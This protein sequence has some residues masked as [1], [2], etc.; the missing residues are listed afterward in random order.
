MSNHELVSLVTVENV[1]F[2]VGSTVRVNFT[3]E[4]SRTVNLDLIASGDL[5]ADIKNSNQVATGTIKMGDL[6]WSNGFTVT[7]EDLRLY[8]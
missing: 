4:V 1:N 5:W 6:Y 3:D 2:I 8:S 7:A